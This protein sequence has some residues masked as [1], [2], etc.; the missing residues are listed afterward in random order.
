MIIRR[1][2]GTPATS[3]QKSNFG[4]KNKNI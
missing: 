3:Q 2:P 4:V 1:T